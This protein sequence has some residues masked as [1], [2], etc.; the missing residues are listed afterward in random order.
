MSA[1]SPAKTRKR[2]TRRRLCVEWGAASER[3]A[4]QAESGDCGKVL[5]TKEGAL[6]AVIDGVGH[7]GEAAAVSRAA[8]REVARNA[9]EHPLVTLRR[10]HEALQSTRGV[11]M[12]LAAF[13]ARD[14][15][16][17][18]LG[19]G[20]VEG[21]LLRADPRLPDETLLL[22]GGLVG[23]Q[24]PPLQA[25]VLPVAKG[26]LVILATD[27][28]R[29][30]FGRAVSRRDPPRRIAGSILRDHSKGT[31]DALVLVVRFRGAE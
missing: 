5:R 31:D 18:W 25:A 8:L 16:L 23:S 13:D 1:E 11:A 30:D 22:R 19:V 17:A 15:V 27:G 9:D 4:G 12:S 24:I 14:R 7:G 3:L 21:L 26:D 2:S 6:V 29:P 10:C 20:N 28:V